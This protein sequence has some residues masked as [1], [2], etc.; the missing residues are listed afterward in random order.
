MATPGAIAA[1]KILMGGK[2]KI[3]T[4]YGTKSVEGVADLIEFETKLEQ[5]MGS[6]QYVVD[7][8]GD[9]SCHDAIEGLREML[10]HIRG[11]EE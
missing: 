3:E 4:P 8:L 2:E 5:L 7:V 1:A 9:E 11:G 10:E 6:A